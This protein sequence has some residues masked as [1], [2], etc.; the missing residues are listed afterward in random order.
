[1]TRRGRFVRP[2]ARLKGDPSTLST[3]IVAIHQKIQG[4]PLVIFF[5]KVSMPKKTERGEP[6]GFFNIH[7]VA[8]HQKLKGEPFGDFF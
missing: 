7:P 2:P 6:L 8:K 5:R 4:G 3:S 1:M